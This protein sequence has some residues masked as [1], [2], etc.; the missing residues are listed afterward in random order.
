M[1]SLPTCRWILV[2]PGSCH[3]T[4]LTAWADVLRFF[5]VTDVV[6]LTLLTKYNLG[7]C[8]SHQLPAALWSAA[9]PFQLHPASRSTYPHLHRLVGRA[10]LA[11]SGL[12]M[13]GVWL[14]D[15]QG[16][17]YHINDFTSLD[18]GAASTFIFFDHVPRLEP[19][20]GYFIVTGLMALVS[21]RRRQIAAHRVW[22][23]RH[24]AGGLW[25]GLQRMLIGLAHMVLRR[26]ADTRQPALQKS[27]F[28]DSAY[29]AIL[30]S[31]IMAELAAADLSAPAPPS[32]PGTGASAD[33][34]AEGSSS[35]LRGAS[36]GSGS[37]T[38]KTKST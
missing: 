32:P 4:Y 14:I 38:T 25:V 6:P 15:Q 34:P 2:F 13:Y 24:V 35:R 5:G 36:E 22:V 18:P 20:A 1:A 21:A 17:H 29:L 12:M 26:F 3:A 11:I 27:I 7:V 37:R 9:V 16:L 28:G 10:L 23:M 8:M 30:L 19:A 33:V 31:I